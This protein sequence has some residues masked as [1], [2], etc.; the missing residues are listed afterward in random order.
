MIK[1]LLEG[2]ILTQS[3]Y[4]EHA[5]LTFRALDSVEGL[6]IHTNPLNWGTTSWTKD[7]QPELLR[8]IEH[9]IKR[10]SVDRENHKINNKKISYDVQ[11]HVGILNEFEKKAEYSVCVTAGIETDRVSLNWL[12]KTWRGVDRLVVPSEHAKSGFV[13]TSYEVEHPKYQNPINV[14]KNPET[15]VRVVPYP[16]KNIKPCHLDLNLNTEFNFLSIALLGIRKNIENMIKWFVEEFHDDNVGLVLKTGLTKGSTSDRYATLKQIEKITSSFPDKKCKVYL[17]HGDLAEQEIQSLYVRK[18]IHA[19]INL[20][21]GE[22]FGL[23]LFEAAYNGMPVIATD[24]SGHLDFLSAPY[25]EKNK[26]KNKKLFA[27]VDFDLKEVP[28]HALWENI[29]IKE[30]QWAFPKQTSYKRQIRKVY[31]DYGMYKKWSSVLK[32]HILKE[33]SDKIIMEK[34]REAMFGE[35]F[36]HK[37]ISNDNK[38]WQEEN[39]KIIRVV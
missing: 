11:V 28:E 39:K 24:W 2:P 33:Y 7:L 31:Q 37:I 19:Y 3:G 23:P 38:E 25:K 9:S 15:A 16:V 14:G 21:H 5:R 36:K 35:G 27:K 20:A 30:S 22:G 26:I 1:V 29:I 32:D 8:K 13:N 18:D 17:L 4:G 12:E 10:F 34:M 6:E